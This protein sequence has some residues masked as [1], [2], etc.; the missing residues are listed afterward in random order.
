MAEHDFAVR[1]A[2]FDWLAEQVQLH[3]DV[4]DWLVLLRG[5]EVEGRRVPLLSQQGIFKPALCELPLSIRTAAD[6]PYD[7]HF[8][9]DRLAYRYRGTDPDHRDNRGLRRLLAL[10]VPL[11]YLHAVVKSRYLVIWPVFV[12]GDDPQSLRFWVQADAAQAKLGGAALSGSMDNASFALEDA[13]REYATRLVHQRLHQRGFRERV[14]AAYREQCAMC[15]LRH[16]DLLDAAHIKPD[17]AGGE[18]VISNGLSLCRIHHGAFDIGVVRVRPTDLRIQVRPDVLREVDGPML[19]H[20]LQALD[21]ERLWTP[22]AAR[23]KP[24]PELLRWKWDRLEHA[25]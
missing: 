19:R 21:G 11:I 6:S 22:S 3:G 1:R 17:S 23:H 9:E 7:D 18:P 10:R 14:L 13:R 24:D 12:V 4:L 2:A 16:R 15:R 5:F 8:L 20:G 25:G